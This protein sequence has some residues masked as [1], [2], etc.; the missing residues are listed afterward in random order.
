M[1]T[2]IRMFAPVS[3]SP[4]DTVV[5]PRHPEPLLRCP[6]VLAGNEGGVLYPLVADVSLG[7]DVRSIQYRLL[8]GQ[9]SACRDCHVCSGDSHVAGVGRP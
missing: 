6:G 7:H 1:P 4:V 5:S 3:A 9:H 8:F 2:N